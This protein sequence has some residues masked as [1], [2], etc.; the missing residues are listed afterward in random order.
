MKNAL[1]WGH[2][3]FLLSGHCGFGKDDFAWRRLQLRV[4]TSGE[5]RI[6]ESGNILTCNVCDDY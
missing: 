6:I 2:H 1:P 5:R 4:M 3:L